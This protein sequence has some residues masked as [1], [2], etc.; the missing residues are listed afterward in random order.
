MPRYGFVCVACPQQFELEL[1]PKAL[2][3]LVFCPLCGEVAQRNSA[4]FA[5][6]RLQKTAPKPVESEPATHTHA[7]AHGPGCGCLG[8]QLA[9]VLSK[10]QAQETP[11]S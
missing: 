9:D 5:T 2:N 8:Y 7:H 11:R 3:Q 10:P 6:V 4:D 1:P